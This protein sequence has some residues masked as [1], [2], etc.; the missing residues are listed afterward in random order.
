MSARHAAFALEAC[1]D[2]LRSLPAAGVRFVALAAPSLAAAGVGDLAADAAVA[3]TDDLPVAYNRAAA[4][5][6]AERA[7]TAA[8]DAAC[9][10]PQ[11]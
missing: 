6:L 9:V 8:V 10:V 3:V 4:E 1:A 11:Q 5:N 7:P 2:L